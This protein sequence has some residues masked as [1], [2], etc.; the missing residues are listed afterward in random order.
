MDN[1]REIVRDFVSAIIYRALF[2]W[3]F[4][5]RRKEIADFFNSAWGKYLCEL[6]NLDA[7][8]ILRRLKAGKI[9]IRNEVI[10]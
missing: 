6:I 3:Q 9:V 8:T 4:E 2:D 10:I 1:D 7:E 5:S